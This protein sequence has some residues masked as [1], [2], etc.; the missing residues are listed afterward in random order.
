MVSILRRPPRLCVANVMQ[1]DD[2][3]PTTPTD[4]VDES[5]GTNPVPQ[6]GDADLIAPTYVQTLLLWLEENRNRADPSGAHVAQTAEASTSSAPVPE[7][8]ESG[9]AEDE[10]T[11]KWMVLYVPRPDVL[12]DGLIHPFQDTS[13]TLLERVSAF[14]HWEAQVR[15]ANLAWWNGGRPLCAV[16]GKKHPPPCR[17]PEYRAAMAAAN[18]QGR[19]LRAELNSARMRAPTLRHDEMLAGEIVMGGSRNGITEWKAKSTMCKTCAKWHSGGAEACTA[20]FCT[21][22]CGLNHMPKEACGEVRKRFINLKL[23]EAGDG[24]EGKTE[25]KKSV[26][27]P[28][29][30][31]ATGS[32]NTTR[33]GVFLDSVGDDPNVIRA[34]GELF[35]AMC[36]KRSAEESAAEADSG[37]KKKDEKKKKKTGGGNSCK[38]K[39]PSPKGPNGPG[40]KG[41]GAS[42][43]FA[44]GV[45]GRR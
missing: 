39:D 2:N 42:R 16:C 6:S 10:D 30:A 27:A 14:N 37:K 12:P 25:K 45:Y 40:G 36:R 1:S 9:D 18:T 17:T 26:P 44:G 13:L 15:A 28:S 33:F 23:I 22:G 38:D 31:T 19:Q 34:A 20:P 21:Q 24:G 11:S 32:T 4:N 29:Q 7:T 43:G 35:L 3:L 8:G 41:G 5:A